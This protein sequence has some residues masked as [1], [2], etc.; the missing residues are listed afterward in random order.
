MGALGSQEVRLLG[1]KELRLRDPPGG[2]GRRPP[3]EGRRGSRL[4]ALARARTEG[5]RAL[6]PAGKRQRGEEGEVL[7]ADTE[8]ACLGRALRVAEPA[9]GKRKRSVSL[10]AGG[11]KSAKTL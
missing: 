6:A 11:S 10:A 8:R 7:H 4:Q 5:E 3:S 9:G 1:N 2:L